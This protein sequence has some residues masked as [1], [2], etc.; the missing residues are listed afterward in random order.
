VGVPS[1]AQQFDVAGGHARIV[2]PP[3]HVVVRA[4]RRG[5]TGGMVLWVAVAAC[6][7]TAVLAATGGLSVRRYSGAHV[8]AHLAVAGRGLYFSRTPDG[9][10]WRLR[11]RP[12]RRQT[13]DRFSCD[14]PPPDVAVREPRRPLG[15]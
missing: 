14:D 6:V 5:D 3:R 10:W 1:P 9:I 11:L 2:P 4:E 12:C 15:P 8:V 13:D 7:S